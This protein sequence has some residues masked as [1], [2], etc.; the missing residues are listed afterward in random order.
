MYDKLQFD[1][2]DDSVISSFKEPTYLNLEECSTVMES[3][4]EV[5]SRVKNWKAL[6]TV[7]TNLYLIIQSPEDFAD[8]QFYLSDILNEKKRSIR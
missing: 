7:R 4:R 5:N 8:E 6:L 2:L 1:A 3:S